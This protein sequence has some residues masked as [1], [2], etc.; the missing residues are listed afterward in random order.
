M[1]NTS[2]AVCITISA[3]V[4]APVAKVW[5]YWTEPR[6]IMQWNS[7][8]EDW[9]TPRAENDLRVGGKFLSRMEARDGSMGFDFSGTYSDVQE[10]QRIAYTLEDGRKV[11]IS[12]EPQGEET[13]V[14][15]SFDA[16]PSHDTGMQQAGWQAILDHFKRY[17]EGAKART[18]HYEI[19]IKAPAA[20]V[21]RTMLDPEQ[22]KVWTAV[23]HPTSHYK[24]SWEKGAKIQFLG[25][26]EQGKTGGMVSRIKENIPNQF[27]SIEHLGLVQ[28][29]KE[30]TS[31][32]EVSDWA[33]ALE[34]YTFTETEGET[35][36]AIDVDTN[37][38]FEAHF[39]ETW[40]K[41][42]QQ[43]KAMCETKV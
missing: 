33:G 31:G 12:F 8:S 32:P 11:E 30:I 41:A 20:Q 23:F 3:Y 40:P 37:Q 7:A 35:L 28:D 22:Y 13:L 36:L 1:E 16:D 24:G 10:H 42:L 19:R 39:A 15:E 14:T 2:K 17:V 26:D 34:N 9:H 29:G 5:Q 6:H 21:Y 38:E 25:L 18:L 4:Q 43:I 27:I